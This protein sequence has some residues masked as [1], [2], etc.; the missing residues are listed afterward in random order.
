MQ[1]ERPI[2]KIFH[3]WLPDEEMM[4]GLELY[5]LDR[6]KWKDLIFPDG[7]LPAFTHDN[8]HQYHFHNL[9]AMEGDKLGQIRA[10]IHLVPDGGSLEELAAFIH[11]AIPI[12]P[13]PA[14]I[15]PQA[16]DNHAL[17]LFGA[18][19]YIGAEGDRVD[20]MDDI[21]EKLARIMVGIWE[22]HPQCT[23]AW[24]TDSILS[25]ITFIEAQAQEE[26]PSVRPV[27]L[28]PSLVDFCALG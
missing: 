2:A 27:S 10:K 18:L 7:P 1:L 9:P 28:G 23:L 26:Y 20:A 15:N 8:G 5:C 12:P 24:I 25:K 6:A 3:I 13:P 21:K 22:D 11:D 4:L 17:V 16:F 19:D 14:P